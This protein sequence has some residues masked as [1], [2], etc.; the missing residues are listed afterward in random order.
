MIKTKGLSEEEFDKALNDFYSYF[1]NGYHF[2]E[3]LKAYL[4]KIGLDE[5]RVTQ[6]SVDSV[7]TLRP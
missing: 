6:R 5:V 3:F 7:L 4:E 2:E 1:K